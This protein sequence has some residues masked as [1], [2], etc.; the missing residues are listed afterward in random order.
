[1]T[2]SKEVIKNFETRVRD[3]CVANA[4]AVAD[5]IIDAL[6]SIINKFPN[7]TA[8]QVNEIFNN[9]IELTVSNIHDKTSMLDAELKE[10][11]EKLEVQN[12]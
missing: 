2:I 10:Q 1:M 8:E 7:S 9:I 6:K 3:S 11:I 12:G 5:T 4:N